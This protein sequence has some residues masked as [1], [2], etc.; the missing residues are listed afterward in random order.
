MA[1]YFSA[2]DS[3]LILSYGYRI[4]LVTV[5][6]VISIVFSVFYLNCHI[7][8]L[9]KRMCKSARELS[10]FI[11]LTNGIYLKLIT[12]LSIRNNRILI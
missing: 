6:R 10:H 2:I 11:G 4:R 1:Y 5:C 9:A 12:S 3:L 8:Y 7:V